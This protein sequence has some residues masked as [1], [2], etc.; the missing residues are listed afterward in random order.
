MEYLELG[1]LDAHIRNTALR[2]DESKVIASQILEGVEWMHNKSIAHR[3]L[4]PGVGIGLQSFIG[5]Y[6]S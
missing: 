1:D 2:E 4:K 3:D 5:A 6:Q